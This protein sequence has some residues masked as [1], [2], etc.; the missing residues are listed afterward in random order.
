MRQVGSFGDAK[1]SVRPVP[2]EPGFPDP[3]MMVTSPDAG[4]TYKGQVAAYNAAAQHNVDVMS[5]YDNASTYN[6]T[7]LPGSYGSL[8]ADNASMGVAGQGG[9]SVPSGG[10]DQPSP[11]VQGG[12][13]PGSGNPGTGNPGGGP[14]ARPGDG[15]SGGPVVPPPSG[16]G[17]G[18]P[19]PSGPGQGGPQPQQ[20]T[21]PGSFVPPTP[22]SPGSG[23]LIPPGTTPVTGGNSVGFGPYPGSDSFGQGR[24][25]G[26]STGSGPRTGAGGQA[27]EAGSGAAGQGRGSGSGAPGSSSGR[28]GGGLPN[29]GVQ[30]I[31]G[32]GPLSPVEGPRGARSGPGAVPM[33]AFGPGRSSEDEEHERASFLQEPDPEAIFG[34]DEQTAPPVIE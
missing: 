1:N 11:V 15:P 12:T 18:V 19:T 31:A 4:A 21:D 14:S 3:W 33:G 6:T 16:P 34:T 28:T 9:G 17:Q 5:A 23:G 25:A 26:F 13:G 7:R 30:P 32:R 2:P 10:G 29:A 24:G 20:G 22:G 8:L 27:R